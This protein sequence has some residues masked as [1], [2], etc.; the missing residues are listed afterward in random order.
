MLKTTTQ[1]ILIDKQGPIAS[2]SLSAN[3]SNYYYK[4]TFFDVDTEELFH[5]YVDDTMNNYASWAHIVT[6]DD[7]RG[8]FDGLK[9]AKRQDNL[10]DADSKPRKLMH[11]TEDEVARALVIMAE[12][13]TVFHRLFEIK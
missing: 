9:L 7:Y 5:T 1:L 6:T 10:I 13:P 2:K 8:L 4:L 3:A 12:R 11:L